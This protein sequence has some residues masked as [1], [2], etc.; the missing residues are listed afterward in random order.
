ML[1]R[2][3]QASGKA[4]FIERLLQEV[5]F[6]ESELGGTDL[7]WE[8]RRGHLALGGYVAMGLLAALCL[9]AWGVSY[10]NNKAYVQEVSAREQ[11]VRQLLQQTPNRASADILVLLPALKATRDL[12]VGDANRDVPWTLG[13]GLYQGRKLDAAARQAYQRMLIDALLPRIALRVEDQVK[14]SIDNPELQYEALKAYVMLHDP[15][16][17]DPKALKAYFSADWDANLPRSVS[18]DD[19][20]DLAGFLD[21][22]LAQ[23]P[24]V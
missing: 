15:Q 13:F 7:K 6:P 5:I 9:T 23:G 19:R 14:T 2:S 11:A 17:F 3:N 21:D 10:V 20:A 1:F 4:F 22:L 12:A 18:T 16:H 8:R 24:A